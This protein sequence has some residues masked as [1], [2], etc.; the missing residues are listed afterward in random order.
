MNRSLIAASILLISAC[1]T[2]NPSAAT[3]E[4]AHAAVE[5]SSPLVT[6]KEVPWKDMTKQQ[7]GRYMVKVV[8]PKMR[9]VFQ[10]YDPKE[11]AKFDCK[12]CHGKGAKERGFEMPTPDLPA[13][14]SSEKEFMA[15][16][17]KEHPEMVKF[18]GEKVSPMTAELLGLP[19]FNHQKPDPNAFSCN[20]CHTLKGTPDADH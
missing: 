14:P 2:S 13:L 12:T 16:T 1:A 6:P 5:D 19:P 9:E 10:A 15:T 11:F 20:G 4:Q 8:S 17:M 7:R 18:M 3:P